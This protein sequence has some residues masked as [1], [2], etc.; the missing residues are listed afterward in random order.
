MSGEDR[1]HV[2]SDQMILESLLTTLC[3]LKGSVKLSDIATDLLDGKPDLGLFCRKRR[4][5]SLVVSSG[6]PETSMHWISEA[7]SAG[8][9]RLGR[10][11]GHLPSSDFDVN[12]RWKH[13]SAPQYTFFSWCLIKCKNFIFLG[14]PYK[15]DVQHGF[16]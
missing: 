13:T 3:E 16:R 6:V 2:D 4:E 5:F 12:Y 1:E 10:E 8:V 7:L 9:K 15:V 14:S 11:V